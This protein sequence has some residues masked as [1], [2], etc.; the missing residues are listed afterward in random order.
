MAKNTSILELVK[1]LKKGGKSGF[2]EKFNRKKFM[3]NL[4]DKYVL[5]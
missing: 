1:A 2:V 5:L 4:H 3:K